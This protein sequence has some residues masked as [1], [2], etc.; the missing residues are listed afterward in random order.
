MCTEGTWAGVLADLHPTGQTQWAQY[1]W[2][3]TV[4][5]VETKNSTTLSNL[6]ERLDLIMVVVLCTGLWLARREE[7]GH[8]LG[9]IPALPSLEPVSP[10]VPASDAP[11]DF[12]LEI[13]SEELPPDDVDAGMA[14]LR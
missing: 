12:V 10:S 7:L 3:D 14:Q 6:C 4:G 9:S 1:R 2:H 11:R 5:L 13:G 8:P